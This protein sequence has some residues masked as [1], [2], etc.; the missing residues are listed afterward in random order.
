MKTIVSDSRESGKAVLHS[1]TFTEWRNRHLS[2]SLA[3][4]PL[5]TLE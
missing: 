4:T 5:K 2:G 1:H 3:V